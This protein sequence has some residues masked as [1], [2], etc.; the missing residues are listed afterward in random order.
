MQ[1]C[2][3]SKITRDELA[4]LLGLSSDGIKYHLQK[5][6]KKVLSFIRVQ[7]EMDFGR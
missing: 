7:H 4:D 5:W 2:N 6:L 1:I 3:N